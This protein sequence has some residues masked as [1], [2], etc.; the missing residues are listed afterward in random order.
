MKILIRSSRSR[1]S[2]FLSPRPR[3]Q[4]KKRT[5]EL[6]Q[7]SLI[8]QKWNKNIFNEARREKKIK[9]L[10]IWV[11]RSLF[12]LFVVVLTCRFFVSLRPKNPPMLKQKQ[13][14]SR[15]SIR[16]RSFPLL[17]L[18][19]S[20]GEICKNINYHSNQKHQLLANRD[21]RKYSDIKIQI[22]KWASNNDL[23]ASS[24][25][26]DYYIK[27]AAAAKAAA[28]QETC[29]PVTHLHVGRCRGNSKHELYCIF[30][31]KQKKTTQNTKRPTGGKEW[32]HRKFEALTSRS[33]GDFA[34]VNRITI[35]PPWRSGGR[36]ESRWM[37]HSRII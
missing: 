28:Q 19:H 8:W 5:F 13:Q 23:G 30:L 25:R 16:D 4:L 9:K 7:S 12:C 35:E 24:K 33:Q 3:R 11:F 18:T 14:H 27:R 22:F 10:D 36:A 37:F 1:L 34:G 31:I 2:A 29:Q 32:C 20:D 26:P 15:R 21:V 17:D 6:E